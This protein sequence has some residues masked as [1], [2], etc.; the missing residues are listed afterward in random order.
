MVSVMLIITWFNKL[1]RIGGGSQRNNRFSVG[2]RNGSWKS[3]R[4]IPGFFVRAGG[5]H[6]CEWEE[7]SK[8]GYQNQLNRDY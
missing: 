5:Y 3:L 7:Y 1:W 4:D 8:L 2:Y 6:K